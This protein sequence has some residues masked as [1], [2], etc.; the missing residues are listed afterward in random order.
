MDIHH[1]LGFDWGEW[2]AIFTLIG[3]AATYAHSNMSRMA[4][5]SSQAE[6]QKLSKAIEQLEKTMIEVNATL[7]SIREDRAED[8]EKLNLLSQEVGK[9]RDWLISDYQRIKALE[10][11]TQDVK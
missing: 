4:A 1:P 7:R 8:R 3:V 6:S 9:H 5:E 2:V 10:E 11:Q